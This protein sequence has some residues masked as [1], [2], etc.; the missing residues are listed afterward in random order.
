M[1]NY[2]YNNEP[3]YIKNVPDKKIY[4]YIKLYIVQRMK[5]ITMKDCNINK[6]FL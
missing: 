2:P 1:I 6:D 4:T 5:K 3:N